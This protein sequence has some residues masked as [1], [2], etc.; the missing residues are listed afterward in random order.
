MGL[1]VLCGISIIVGLLSHYAIRHYLLAIVVGTSVSS[2]CFHLMVYIQLGYLDKF[3]LLIVIIVGMVSLAINAAIGIPF[4][5]VRRRRQLRPGFCRKCGYNLHGLTE[6]RC[7]ECGT[8]CA[9]IR[10]ARKITDD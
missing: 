5:L 8:P 9:P 10:M 7:P 4:S 2:F 6:N 3:F 1:V